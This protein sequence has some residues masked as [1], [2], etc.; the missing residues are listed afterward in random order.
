MRC[1]IIIVAVVVGSW[2]RA[3]SFALLA[4]VGPGLGAGDRLVKAAK[5]LLAKGGRQVLH[6]EL[7]E[8]VVL[9]LRVLL[10][11]EAAGKQAAQDQQRHNHANH[12]NADG[13]G[14]GVGVGW[15]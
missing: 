5:G 15:G 1:N 13:I 9:V 7:L 14:V 2:R 12:L 8:V 6:V 11:E 10:L 3:S 4:D